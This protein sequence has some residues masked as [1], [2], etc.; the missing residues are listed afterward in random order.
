MAA[1]ELLHCDGFVAERSFTP[2]ELQVLGRGLSLGAEI[3][4]ALSHQIC[5]VMMLSKRCL[6]GGEFLL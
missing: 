6:A 5:V 4:H 1:H 3:I 2:S